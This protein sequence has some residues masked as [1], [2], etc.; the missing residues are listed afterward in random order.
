MAHKTNYVLVDYENVQPQSVALL[1][2]G[3]FRLLVFVGSQKPKLPFEFAQSVQQLGEAAQY[4]VCSGTGKNALDFHIAC[5]LGSLSVA[6][7]EAF[8]HVISRDTGFDPLLKHL[9]EKGIACKRLGSVNDIPILQS[10]S[11]KSLEEQV[12]AAYEN[13]RKRPA[14]RPR[15]MKT[16]SSSLFSLFGGKLDEAV[17]G[18]VI[19]HLRKRGA[20]RV[21]GSNVSYSFPA[22][23]VT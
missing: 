8:F 11:G 2:G 5:Y 6:E 4:I 9:L 23:P 10:V 13:L 15:K 1:K 14:N 16:L 20:V 3:P 18:E 7:P 19:D 22:E 12:A 17:I 21:E